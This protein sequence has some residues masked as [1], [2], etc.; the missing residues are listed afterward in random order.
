MTDNCNIIRDLMPLVI[1]EAASADSI[2]C[3]T[4]HVE[5]C[6]SC[7]TYYEGMKH[8]SDSRKMQV[9]EQQLFEKAALRLRKKRRLRIIRNIFIGMLIGCVLMWGGLRV[10]SVSS[11]ALYSLHHTMARC[12]SASTSGSS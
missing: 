12:F 7:R 5:K 4:V 11:M 6:E 10:W 1:D 2:Q 3:V 9:E 8:I